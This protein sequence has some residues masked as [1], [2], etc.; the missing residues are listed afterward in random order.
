MNNDSKTIL[1]RAADVTL[2]Y[3]GHTAAKGVNFTTA[4]GDYLCIVGENG[5][6][7]STLLKA[8]TGD[9]TIA[10]GK[11]EIDSSLQKEG[12]GYLPQYSK[13][14]RDFPATVREVVQSGCVKRD[15]WGI[16]WGSSARKRAA[17]AMHLLGVENIADKCFAELSGGQ[18][19]RVLLSRAVCVSERL[20]LLDEPVTGLDPDAAHEMYAAIRMINRERGC[21]V[22]MVSHDIQCALSEAGYVLSM[23]RGHSFYGTVEEYRAHEKIDAAKD[24]ERHRDMFHR[25]IELPLKHPLGHSGCSCHNGKTSESGALEDKNDV[26]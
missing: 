15:P 18:R 19:Q 12:I 16:L 25:G 6:G 20:L 11:L 17:E 26:C 10:A 4:A 1:I 14:Q 13:I 3:E 24:K 9:V 22:V 23:C 7:K 21:T 8:I 5:S 2:A